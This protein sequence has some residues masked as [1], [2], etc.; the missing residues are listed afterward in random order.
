MEPTVQYS[1]HEVIFTGDYRELVVWTDS[2]VE[3]SEY[4]VLR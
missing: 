2:C 1:E 4:A 3:P